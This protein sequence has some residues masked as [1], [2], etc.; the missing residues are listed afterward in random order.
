ML[1][2][3]AYSDRTPSPPTFKSARHQELRPLHA[4]RGGKPPVK[5]DTRCALL[6][7]IAAAANVHLFADAVAPGDA[8]ADVVHPVRREGPAAVEAVVSVVAAVASEAVE[9]VPGGHGAADEDA[10]TVTLLAVEA[11]VVPLG[12]LGQ[13]LL[14]AALWK[15]RKRRS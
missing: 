10:L 6:A 1:V 3:P 15:R 12:A 2:D 13:A 5:P 11:A 4:S 8:V 7:A 14:R 9:A